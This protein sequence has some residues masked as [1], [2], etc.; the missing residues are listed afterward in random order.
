V[1]QAMVDAA[2]VLTPD[3]RVQLAEKMHQRRR[4]RG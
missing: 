2:E 1:L 3:Q 4:W